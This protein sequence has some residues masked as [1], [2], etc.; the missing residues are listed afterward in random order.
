MPILHNLFN[1]SG[2]MLGGQPGDMAEHDVHHNTLVNRGIVLRWG[3]FNPDSRD[4]RISRNLIRSQRAPC[5][6]ASCLDT[7]P[8]AFATQLKV[9]ANRLETTSST[10]MTDTECNGS[11]TNMNWAAP[12]PARSL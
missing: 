7:A 11:P 9:A 10:A 4:R 3:A 6:W 1:N 5:A 8:A 12:G 2:A